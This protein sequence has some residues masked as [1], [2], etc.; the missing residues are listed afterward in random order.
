LRTSDDKSVWAEIGQVFE[1]NLQEWDNDLVRRH[2][3]ISGEVSDI[4]ADKDAQFKGRANY[5]RC[6]QLQ[7]PLD[8][9]VV[10]NHFVHGCFNSLADNMRLGWH[11]EYEQLLS[12]N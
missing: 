10:P 7:P 11:P 1:E 3:L 12:G 5:R 6:A 9:R 4:Y 8:G 2:S